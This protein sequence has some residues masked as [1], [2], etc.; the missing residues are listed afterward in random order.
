MALLLAKEVT[1]PAKYSD[2][3]DVFS[4]KLANILSEQ[5]GV[6]EHTIELEKS[7]QPPY[8]P[9]Y[10]LRP[11]EF[12]TFKTYI[13]TNL[14]IGFIYASNSSTDAPILFVCK[15]NDTFCLCVNY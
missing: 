7:K 11:V 13:K 4:K 10:R 2:F 14:A 3:A 12:K 1:V 8:G 6:I 5:I 9:I 15:L